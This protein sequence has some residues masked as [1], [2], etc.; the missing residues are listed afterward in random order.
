MPQFITSK[1]LELKSSTCTHELTVPGVFQDEG[2]RVH[3]ACWT[4]VSSCKK[5][6]SLFVH[7]SG[8]GYWDDMLK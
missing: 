7:D 6:G 4:L 2:D 3:R 5:C 1:M 8:Y